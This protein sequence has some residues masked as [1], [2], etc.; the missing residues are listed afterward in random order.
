M[1]GIRVPTASEHGG[2]GW[3][4]E[5][6]T[7]NARGE[8]DSHPKFEIPQ[9][10]QASLLSPKLSTDCQE[11]LKRCKLL[12]LGLW[13]FQDSGL[14]PRDVPFFFGAQAARD[15]EVSDRVVEGCDPE[16]PKPP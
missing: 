13:S 9:T 5:V 1:S 6:F 16:A 15:S 14:G 11:S 4:L 10:S 12:A 7:T 2:G 8:E 3:T